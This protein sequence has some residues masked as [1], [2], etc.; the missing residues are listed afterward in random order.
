M[1]LL[2]FS[3]LLSGCE[4]AA[5][6]YSEAAILYGKGE[7]SEAESFFISAIESGDDAPEVHIGHA[8]NLLRLERYSNAADEFLRV[9]SSVTDKETILAIRKAMLDA[10]LKDG[11]LAGAAGVCDEIAALLDEKEESD[12]YLL[13][14]AQ[15]RADIYSQREDKELYKQS[16]MKLIE[17]KDY[18][19][20]E[21]LRLYRLE[22]DDM[23][24][25]ARLKMADDI[26]IYSMGHSAYIKDYEPL[27]LI[28]FDAARI[29]S[30]VE[31]E[32]DRAYYFA[33]AE[34]FIEQ[35]QRNQSPE[36]DL[37]KFKIVMAEQ[38]GK[39]ELAYKLLGVY[40]NHCPED[41]FAVKEMKYLEKRVGVN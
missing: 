38:E 28:M 7:Y 34:E 35:A 15:I 13:E 6:Y 16:L 14:A 24:Y 3:F 1:L 18:A 31:Y 41:A 12:P 33:R 25:E 29:S 2:V 5:S 32:H 10:Y 37:L 21:Y 36:E 11:N 23:N 8:Y 22:D 27:I 30:Y 9:L 26:I 17:L 20:E 39:T 40:L 4:E 19:A